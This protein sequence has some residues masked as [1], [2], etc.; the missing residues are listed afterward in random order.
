[1]SNK[2]KWIIGGVLAFV[3]VLGCCLYFI[4]KTTPIDITL[5]ASKIGDRNGAREDLGTVEIR[6]HGTLKEYLFR[7]SELTL[8][9]DDFDIFHNILSYT[10]RGPDRDADVTVKLIEG[11]YTLNLYGKEVNYNASF[12]ANSTIT[13]E[14]SAV[15]RVDF[16]PDL[17][18]WVI[19]AVPDVLIDEAFEDDPSFD[20]V[21]TATVE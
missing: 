16:S 3:L 7:P 10:K 6:V 4:P 9:I 8:E 18:N 13:G 11:N 20:C 5:T 15:I 19:I 1:M 12:I 17:K 2:M 21:Y 14:E